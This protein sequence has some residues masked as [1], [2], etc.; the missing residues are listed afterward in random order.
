MRGS[1][2][3]WC[4]CD[5]RQQ[6]RGSS[7]NKRH[8]SL[9]LYVHCFA[10]KLNLI[11]VDTCKAIRHAADFFALL[12]EIYNFVSDSCVHAKWI[13]LQKTEMPDQVPIELKRLCETRLTAQIRACDAVK[14]RLPIL[15]DLLEMIAEED[16]REREH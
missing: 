11:V 1:I 14:S 9:A 12:L 13:E 8:C 10:H 6:D 3:R 16:N 15:L 4:E 7:E 2:L 5:E